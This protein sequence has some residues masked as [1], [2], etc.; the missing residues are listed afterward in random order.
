MNM[1]A[2]G[3]I[4]ILGAM[5]QV[6]LHISILLKFAQTLIASIWIT[7]RKK[8]AKCMARKS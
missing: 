2:A 1:K 6:K 7:P 4:P 5:A 8:S 3:E